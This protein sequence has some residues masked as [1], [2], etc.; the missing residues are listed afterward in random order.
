MPASQFDRSSDGLTADD[1]DLLLSDLV[2]CS[3]SRPK[4]LRLLLGTD[5]GA[6]A[7]PVVGAKVP[8]AVCVALVSCDTG[9]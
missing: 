8:D 1:I 7:V 6:G 4:L 2:D 5:E 9:M 3:G